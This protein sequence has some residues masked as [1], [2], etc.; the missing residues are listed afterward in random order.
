MV[1]AGAL[2]DEMIDG[3]EDVGEYDCVNF[4]DCCTVVADAIPAVLSTPTIVNLG[5]CLVV[6]MGVE[7]PDELILLALNVFFQVFSVLS[8]NDGADVEDVGDKVVN[9]VVA[10]STN[11][12]SVVGAGAVAP[13]VSN[14]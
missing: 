4:T 9:V 14:V 2:I 1:Y 12:N 3:L 11:T 13:T 7:L 8:V 10:S 6:V 5:N